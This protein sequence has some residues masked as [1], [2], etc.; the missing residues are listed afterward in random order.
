MNPGPFRGPDGVREYFAWIDEIVQDQRVES[1][2]VIEVDDDRVI[3]VVNMS[4][5]TA[6]FDGRLETD[7]AWLIT[8]SDR[9]ATHIQT[10]TDKDQALE[11][12][13]LPE[14]DAHAD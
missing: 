6:Q 9:L 5:R 10:F 12:V 7:W 1:V 11:A 13:G 8:F 14:Q 3:A 2:E 4:G